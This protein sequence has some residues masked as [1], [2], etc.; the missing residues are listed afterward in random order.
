MTDDIINFCQQFYASTFIPILYFH[1]PHEIQWSC[2]AVLMEMSTQNTVMED[3]IKFHKNPDYFITDSHAYFGFVNIDQSPSKM[4]FIVLGPVFSTNLSKEVLEGFLQECQLPQEPQEEMIRVLLNSP[5]VTYHRFLSMLSFLHL[6]VNGEKIDIESH[7]NA[8]MDET[9]RSGLLQRYSLNIYESR[10]NEEFHNTYE[11]EQAL[12][13][14]VSH[15]DV[16]RLRETLARQPREFPL[17]TGR[18]SQDILRHTRNTFIVTT[19]L[20]VRAAIAGG[21]DTEQAYQL[22]DLYIQECE[23]TQKIDAIHTLLY[24]MLVDLAT[25]V[26]ALHLPMDGVSKEV[27]RCV[28]Y[29]TQHPHRP[30]Q[31]EDVAEFIG[32]SRSYVTKRFK[33]ELGVDVS[34]FIMRCKLE[35]A[36]SL[37]AYTDKPLSEISTYLCFSSQAYFQN[38][39]KKKYGMTP[40]Q[41]RKKATLR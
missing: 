15:G 28:Q 13:D 25:R 21:L 19:A 40:M 30:L 31:V 36:K 14:S 38:V 26:G 11:F 24:T 4:D 23:N 35:E 9:A 18:L 3:K 16:P 12:L 22:S 17:K 10:E 1:W 29:I 8:R 39:F 41:Y 33:E 34:G 37:L 27:F 2:P 5:R 7:F 6:C 20:A 32:R